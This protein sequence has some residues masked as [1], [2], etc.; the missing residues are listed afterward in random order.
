MID[1]H[2]FATPRQPSPGLVRA[3]LDALVDRLQAAPVFAARRSD[4]IPSWDPVPAACHADVDRWIES[5]PADMAV[6]GWLHEPFD[7]LEHRFVAHS[8]VRSSDGELIDVTLLVQPKQ[9]AL[10]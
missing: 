5:H 4:Q 9:A 7:G 3:L 6:R 8:I 1:G 2:T 10:Y